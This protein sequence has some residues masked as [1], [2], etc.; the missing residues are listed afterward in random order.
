MRLHLGHWHSGRFSAEA[1]TDKELNVSFAIHPES[2]TD[3]NCSEQDLADFVR[4][5]VEEHTRLLSSKSGAIRK[6]APES[7][8][9]LVDLPG[10]PQVCVKEFRWRG[11]LHA[12]KGLF[13]PTQGL[14]TYRNGR[15]LSE[16]GISC[17]GPLALVRKRTF[18]IVRSEWVIMGVI[19]GALELDRYIVKQIALGW[20]PDEMRG[21]ARLLGRFIGSIHAR[22]VFHSDLKTCNI[23][24]S[25]SGSSPKPN[26]NP[27]ISDEDPSAS[28]SSTV[29]FSLLDY[30]D[31]TFAR[32]VTD[33]KRIKN[34]LQIFLSTPMAVKASQRLLFLDEY[35]LHAGLS[36]SRKRDIAREVVK[37]AQGKDVLYVGF[38]GDVCERWH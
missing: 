36:R 29:H 10:F 8:V 3:L 34:L 24:V 22:G 25:G 27:P 1:D 35:A 28:S 23:V 7:A 6:D 31:V 37:A 17:A 30:D 38:D 33:K 21:L 12:L 26:S 14:R 20:T 11:W 4:K 13:R 32:E 5:A 18:G 2:S 19:P 9:T 16:M 15:Q